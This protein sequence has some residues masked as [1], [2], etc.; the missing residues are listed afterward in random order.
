M[1]DNLGD[2]FESMGPLPTTMA[3]TTAEVARARV[4]HLETLIHKT[5][6]QN[7][8][9]ICWMDVFANLAKEVG[10]DFNPLKLP[11]HQFEKNCARFT[12][13]LYAKKPYCADSLTEYMRT[14]L[15]VA[16]EH[17]Q[18]K[19]MLEKA[20]YGVTGTPLLDRLKEALEDAESYHRLLAED[21]PGDDN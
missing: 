8:D 6:T 13:D 12:E 15:L 16:E 1:P 9:D 19:I 4:R 3:P 7:M 2:V 18:A 10:V 21:I 5:V 20:G 11:R 14:L 17:R